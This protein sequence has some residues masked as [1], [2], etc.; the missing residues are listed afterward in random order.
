M[1]G[2]AKDVRCNRNSTLSGRAE[3]GNAVLA[4]ADDRQPSL[5]RRGGLHVFP[6]TMPRG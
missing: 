2:P 4:D 6:Q 1:P 5:L 3:A